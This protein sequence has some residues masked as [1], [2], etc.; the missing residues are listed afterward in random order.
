MSEDGAAD[1]D[2]ERDERRLVD[3]TP[4]QMIAASEE[5]EFIAKIAVAII[6]VDVEEQ[7]GKSDS[8]DNQHPSGKE[9]LVRAAGLDGSGR[10]A[11]HGEEGYREDRR[12]VM[13][14]G[15]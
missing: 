5:I 12:N 8:R 10:C 1:V 13:D 7:L 2:K 15:T 9:R 14:L 6:E 11:G 4:R 3:I